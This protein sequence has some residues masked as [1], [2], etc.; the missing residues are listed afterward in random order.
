M[1]RADSITF[2]AQKWMMVAKTRSIV[3]FRDADHLEN[4][5]RIRKSYVREHDLAT[6][7]SE[8]GIPGTKRADVLKL[9]L[10]LESLGRRGYAAYVDHTLDLTDHFTPRV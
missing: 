9:W 2:N 3:M 1:E 10:S 7:L 4:Y 6:D 8:T 5:F